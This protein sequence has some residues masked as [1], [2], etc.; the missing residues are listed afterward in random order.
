VVLLEIFSRENPFADQM[1]FSIPV[2]V[3]KGGRPNINKDVPKAIVRIIKQ[4]WD[5]KP[6]KRPPFPKILQQ[7]ELIQEEGFK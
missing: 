3:C 7:L 6:A 2:I 1:S 5:D 4:C